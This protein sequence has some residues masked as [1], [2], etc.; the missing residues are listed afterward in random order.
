MFMVAGGHFAGAVVRVSKPDE[1]D[2]PD[3]EPAGRKKKAMKKPKPEVEVLLHK[4]FHRY[5]STS[6]TVNR[7]IVLISVS[8]SKA[9]WV[10]I[11]ERQRKGP[12]QERGCSSSSIRR[13]GFARCRSFPS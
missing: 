5:T 6:L 12:G 8:P 13:T 7:L 3:A 9:G 10:P 2:A 1:E 4:T 11:G